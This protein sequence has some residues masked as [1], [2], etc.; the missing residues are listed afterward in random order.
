MK[1]SPSPHTQ[2]GA[3]LVVGLIMLVLIT[4]MVVSAFTLSNSN[5]KSVGNLQV[6]N[7]AIAAANKA[8]EQVVN[9]WDFSSIPVAQEIT[10]DLTGNGTDNYV[11]EIA[12]PVCVS[13]A[14]HPGSAYQ[15]GEAGTG[16]N[17]LT[18]GDLAAA[19]TPNFDI[20]WDVDGKSTAPGTSTSV[21]VHQGVARTLTQTQCN[22]ACP[23][24]PGQPCA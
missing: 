8:I 18:K 20:I 13:A 1:Q 11:V 3:T 9:S 14:S 2:R 5:L 21:E 23:P 10:V 22:A 6:H 17:A 19:P 4:V 12:A 16:V 24:A 15:L 7:E